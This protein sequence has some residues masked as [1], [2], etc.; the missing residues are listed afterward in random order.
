M[1]EVISL[2]K[3]FFANEAPRYYSALTGL[4]AFYCGMI[5]VLLLLRQYMRWENRR[6]DKL[7]G[8]GFRTSEGADVKGILEGFGDKTDLS[9]LHFRYGLQ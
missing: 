9:N 1:L 5:A 6:R 2:V 8:S 7:I 4:I 3:H